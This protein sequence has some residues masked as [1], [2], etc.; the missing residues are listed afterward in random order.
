MN[1]ERY[2]RQ[3]A[4][5]LTVRIAERL[6]ERQQKLDRMAAWDQSEKAS[7][8]RPLYWAAPLAACLVAVVLIAVWVKQ[9]TSPLDELGIAC[10]ELTEYRA[11]SPELDE[12]AGLLQNEEFDQALKAT[13]AAL[14]ESD[15]LIKEYSEWNDYLGEDEDLVYSRN[16]ERT[17]NSELR[18]TYI[19]LL[20]KKGQNRSAKK[21]I[22]KYLR[23]PE[24][25]EHME[26]AE[27]LLEK[28]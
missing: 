21:E 25:C 14:G 19:Y 8:L 22:R 11:A 17:V 23:Y 6:G 18:W 26:E 20:L 24:F 15:A 13:A 7:R 9:E 10:P 28:I 3:E 12:I 2:L 16:L 27:Q 1:E 5:P 4:D